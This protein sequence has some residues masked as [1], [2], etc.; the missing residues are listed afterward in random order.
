MLDEGIKKH[1]VPGGGDETNYGSV[2]VAPLIF[3]DD[4]ILSAD[5]VEGA[6][7]ANQRIDK[8][9]KQ[10]NL[11]LNQDKTVCT[12]IDSLKQRK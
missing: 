7:L 2:P 10:L 3:M 11:S 12:M 1:F 8:V 4:I 6:R 9:V 5:G